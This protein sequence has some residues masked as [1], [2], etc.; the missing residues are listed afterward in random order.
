MLQIDRS[1]P[2]ASFHV[3]NGYVSKAMVDAPAAG[4]AAR[5]H[6]PPESLT[7][8][9]TG[10][11]RAPVSPEAK[12][13]RSRVEPL[14]AFNAVHLKQDQVDDEVAKLRMELNSVKAVLWQVVKEGMGA[15]AVE[16]LKLEVQELGAQVKTNGGTKLAEDMVERLRAIEA[17]DLTQ[18]ASLKLFEA[19]VMAEQSKL[20][21]LQLEVNLYQ[22]GL[23]K[24]PTPNKAAATLS[25]PPGVEPRIELLPYIQLLRDELTVAVAQLKAA[26][27]AQEQ[28]LLKLTGSATD[29]INQHAA[30]ASNVEEQV[31]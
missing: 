12:K 11:A 2:T 15:D 14:S 8:G 29:S 30:A 7:G 6:Q 10:A 24:H 31:A 5:E 17:N 23:V 3:R 9:A 28:D 27:E 26:D 20:T 16:S 19:L 4:P 21:K 25:P 22:A 1:K 18:K 13:G